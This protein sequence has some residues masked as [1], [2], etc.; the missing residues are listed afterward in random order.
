MTQEDKEQV[1]QIIKDEL[2]AFIV[3]DRYLFNKH[4]QMMDGKNIQLAQGTGTQIGTE[5][6]QKVA[7]FGVTPVIQQNHIADAPGQPGVYSS[8]EADKIVTALNSAILVL[9]KFGFI[10]TS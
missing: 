9:E 3:S 6:T 5:I 1:K 7:F 8:T 2:A 10:K 4:I